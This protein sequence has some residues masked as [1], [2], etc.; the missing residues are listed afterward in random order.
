MIGPIGEMVLIQ[1]LA[2]Q[3][4]HSLKNPKVGVFNASGSINFLIAEGAK[5]WSRD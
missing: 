2:L 3:S 1:A 5:I 4:R